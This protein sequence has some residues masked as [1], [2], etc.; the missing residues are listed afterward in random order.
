MRTKSYIVIFLAAIIMI[1][2]V[3][4]FLFEDNTLF[5]D[6][7]SANAEYNDAVAIDYDAQ[8]VENNRLQ[9]E[10]D[11][12]RSEITVLNANLKNIAA[13]HSQK[14][15]ELR[16]EKT[17]EIS[18]QATSLRQQISDLENKIQIL[19]DQQYK[20]ELYQESSSDIV[21]SLLLDCTENTAVDI[22]TYFAD[23]SE[24]G[25]YTVKF[26]GYI[27]SLA[28][29]MDQIAVVGSDYN[30]S[31]GN[32]S[33]RQIYACYNNMRP[34]DKAT[35]L[36]WF[37]N[38]YI[39]GSGGIGSIEGGYIV[40]GIKL[41]GLI[42]QE[43]INS[44]KIA[45]QNAIDENKT[46]YDE[47]IASLEEQR[48]KSIIEA[49]NGSSGGASQDKIDALVNS[50]NAYYDQRVAD[51]KQECSEQEAII[52]KNYDDRISALEQDFVQGEFNLADP[53][54]LIYTLDITFAVHSEK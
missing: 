5:K 12:V 20:D 36:K 13:E 2:G 51:A 41:S 34:W 23:K 40:D 49:Y 29:V 26:V 33:L 31:I 1:A 24:Q 22:V 54:M 3:Y 19:E 16:L 28:D 52:A 44:L 15:I 43:T 48:L 7:K 38:Q 46:K 42:G 53:D 50:L 37:Q 14:E 27:D 32:M 18:Q 25:Y 45:K 17:Q 4:F 39:T 47:I 6:L 35:L 9:G 8:R 10:I 30:I 11:F 21:Y